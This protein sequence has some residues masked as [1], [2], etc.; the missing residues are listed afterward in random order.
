MDEEERERQ[1]VVMGKNEGAGWGRYL[2]I[3]C[4]GAQEERRK[5]REKGS[6]GARS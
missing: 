6:R 5:K 2:Q 3:N 4:T 1:E